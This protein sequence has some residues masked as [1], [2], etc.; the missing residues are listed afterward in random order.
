MQRK[1]NAKYA[2]VFELILSHSV[3]FGQLNDFE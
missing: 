3:G 1:M 2:N